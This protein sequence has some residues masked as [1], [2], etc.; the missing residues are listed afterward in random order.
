MVSP[1]TDVS[2]APAACFYV[3]DV[4]HRRFA[5]RE[6][7]FRYHTRWL[8][9]DLEQAQNAFRDRW[10]W[11]FGRRNLQSVLRRD[12]F[13]DP[14]KEPADAVRDRVADELGF[15]PQGPVCVLTTPR[16]FG[17]GFNPVSFYWCFERDGRRPAA[18]LAEITNTPWGERHAYA[19]D[20]R[21]SAAKRWIYR[22]PKAFHVSPFHPMDLEYRWTFAC[23]GE[24]LF[25]HM[26]NLLPGSDTCVFDATMN[27]ARRPLSAGQCAR[28]ILRHPAQ[29]ALVLAAIHWQAA[30]LWLKR[31]PF[32]EHPAKVSGPSPR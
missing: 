29:G 30:R 2:S 32:H 6:H 13:G 27:L 10:L 25:V 28:A 19:F 31:T 23:P 12:L 24:R 16:S 18:V 14:S 9:L 5:P 15:R 7:A 4:R 22:F 21:D 17:L 26:E 1:S 11:S 20:A 3:G 8:Y